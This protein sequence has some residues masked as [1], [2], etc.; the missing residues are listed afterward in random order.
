MRFMTFVKSAENT[1]GPP[2]PALMQAI[3][4]LGEE[5]SKAGLLVEMG[6][7]MPSAAGARIRID[8]GK[9]TVLDGPFTE[10]KEVI[11]GYAVFNFPTRAEAMK[12]CERFMELHRE[13]WPIWEGESEIRQVMEFEGP[14]QG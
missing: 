10:A 11:G 5:A 14:A 12:W 3:A 9:L 4:A 1:Y 13:T 7:L 2:P 6:G 8:K